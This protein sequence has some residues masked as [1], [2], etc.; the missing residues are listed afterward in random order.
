MTEIK[1]ILTLP[2]PRS[3][4]PC[5]RS[6]SDSCGVGLDRNQ[7]GGQ[8]EGTVYWV[9][10]VVS[11]ST[12]E[13]QENV[14]CDRACIG[15]RNNLHKHD[16]MFGPAWLTYGYSFVVENKHDQAMSA[17]FKASQLMAGCHLPQLYIKLEYSFTNNTHLTEKFFSQALEVALNDLFVLNELCVTAFSSGHYE[18]AEKY[19]SDALLRVESVSRS[20]LSSSL[21]DKW[22]IL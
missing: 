11:L 15:M 19:L 13:P 9:D 21:S 14:Y 2:H 8:V 1:M 17:Y 10:K 22:E 7:S 3:L 5:H 20:G 16:V 12:K 4:T 18:R 6:Y